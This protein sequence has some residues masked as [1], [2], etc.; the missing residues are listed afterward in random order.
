MYSYS[1]DIIVKKM[2]I[3]KYHEKSTVPKVTCV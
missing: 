1:D 2:S 3:L